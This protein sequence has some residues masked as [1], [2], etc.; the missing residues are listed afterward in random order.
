M[1]IF[2]TSQERFVLGIETLN[3]VPAEGAEQFPLLLSRIIGAIHEPG[4]A[5]F[6]P[7]EEAQLGEVLGLGPD[8]VLYAVQVSAFIFECAAKNSVKAPALLGALAE[9]GLNEK[10]VSRCCAY[11][12]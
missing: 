3:K 2:P 7:K 11:E 4:A 10:M 6:T 5:V 12:D 9:A 1:S 8:G